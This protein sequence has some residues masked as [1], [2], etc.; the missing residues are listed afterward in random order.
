MGIQVGPGSSVAVGSV[1]LDVYAGEG[2]ITHSC[3]RFR[4]RV[5]NRFVADVLEHSS[6]LKSVEGFQYKLR[7]QGL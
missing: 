5:L 1:K 6:R 2:A 7:T 4:P 3:A